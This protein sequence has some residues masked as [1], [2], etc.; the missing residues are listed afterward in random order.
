MPEA[1]REDLI[2]LQAF[3]AALRADDGEALDG[4]IHPEHGM[5]IWLHTAGVQPLP[6]SIWRAGSGI[7]IS[8]RLTDDEALAPFAGAGFWGHVADQ[9]DLPV[10]FAPRGRDDAR[11]T[12]SCESESGA[13]VAGTRAWLADDDLR[14]PD[15][16]DLA[17]FPAS[18]AMTRGLVHFHGYDVEVWLIRDLGKRYV[19]HVV[20]SS[21]CE[22]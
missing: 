10:D 14:I 16:A 20:V 3:A 17:R 7:R 4:L 13:P 5:W 8:Q 2:T 21:P 15:G 9:L 1:F 19:A 18:A 6:A 22:A 11:Y 12:G